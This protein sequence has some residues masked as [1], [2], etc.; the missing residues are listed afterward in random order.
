MTNRMKTERK[1]E[2]GG[3]E[4]YKQRGKEKTEYSK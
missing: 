4:D 3:T 1:L 2:E